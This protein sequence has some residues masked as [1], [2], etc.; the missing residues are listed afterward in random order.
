[1]TTT[2]T[3]SND[4]RLQAAAERS[5]PVRG[6]R[7][8][9]SF[10]EVLF[11]V[12]VLGIGF[13]MVA[14]MFPVTISQTQETMRESAGANV[15]RA[16]I[17]YLGSPGMAR[18]EYFPPTDG[19]PRVDPATSAPPPQVWAM[20]YVP[21]DGSEVVPPGL[22]AVSGNMISA[23]NPRMAWVPLYMR[24]RTADGLPSSFAQVF[25]VVCQARN[26]PEY[27]NDGWSPT[28]YSDVIRDP[29][30]A[31][32]WKDRTPATL[33]PRL[34]TVDV[35]WNAVLKRGVVKLRK[36]ARAPAVNGSWDVVAPGAFMIVADDNRPGGTA[37][38]RIYRVGAQNFDVPLDTNDFEA[39]YELSPEGDMIHA[40]YDDDQNYAATDDPK[41]DR[42]NVYV[43]GRGW[44]NPLAPADGRGGPAQDLGV[45]TGFVSIQAR[46]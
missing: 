11:A 34:V 8:G 12:M 41:L 43:M 27:V 44:L 37:N 14:A 31:T 21:L 39:A 35:E 40:N 26:R 22:T 33:E 25:V 30:S 16:A 28:T 9:F 45:Y 7:G 13:I 6:R 38:G 46:P 17:A 29:A 1:M 32:D 10:T 15:A 3:M 18:D 2:T 23:E 20:P 19:G 42:A 4:T 24:G 36:N 5:G